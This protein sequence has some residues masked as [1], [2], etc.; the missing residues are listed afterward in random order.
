M[1]TLYIPI[2]NFT[3]CIYPKLNNTFFI[4]LGIPDSLLKGIVGSKLVL[5]F[6]KVGDSY[7]KTDSV[8]LVMSEN[9]FKSG[10]QFVCKNWLGQTQNVS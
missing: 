2:V 9:E 5:E 4:L 7:Y 10:E 6:D 3:N 1:V 8:S